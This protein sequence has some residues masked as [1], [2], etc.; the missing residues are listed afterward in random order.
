MRDPS[1][2]GKTSIRV[3]KRICASLCCLPPWGI[4]DYNAPAC[5]YARSQTS[6]N[7]CT[8][9]RSQ[10]RPHTE[11]LTRAGAHHARGRQADTGGHRRTTLRGTGTRRRDAGVWGRQGQGAHRRPWRGTCLGSP[12]GKG[13]PGPP[14]MLHRSRRLSL[15][16]FGELIAASLVCYSRRNAD[17]RLGRE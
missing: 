17:Q 13:F 6:T 9:A 14:R 8:H 5:P 15:S 11:T 7:T 16:P 4:R 3:P 1:R 12:C 10:A 2:R